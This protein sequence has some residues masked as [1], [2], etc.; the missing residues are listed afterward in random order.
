MKRTIKLMAVAAIAAATMTSCGGGSSSE[1]LLFGK[2]PAIYAELKAE[3]DAIKEDAKSISSVSDFADLAEKENKIKEEYTGKLEEAAKALDGK[4]ITFAEGDIKVT[5][6]IS[7]TYKSI[8][9]SDLAPSFEINGTAEAAA[10]I[11]PESTYSQIAYIVYIVGYDA[12]NQEVFTNR[13][14]LIY[15]EKVGDK[16]VIKAGT[17]IKFETLYFSARQAEEYSKATSLKLIIK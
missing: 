2:V 16:D 4:E 6:P 14:G 7:L 10:D 11:T 8:S 13:A 12:D 1:A 17:Q 5:A 3:K 15:G 9:K